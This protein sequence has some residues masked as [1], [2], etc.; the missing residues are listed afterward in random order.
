MGAKPSPADS[1][2]P[3]FVDPSG[4]RWKV[5]LAILGL[6]GLL[7]ALGLYLLAH[8]LLETPV[9]SSPQGGARHLAVP[10]PALP[11]HLGTVPVFGDGILQE[12]VV[13]RHVG[14]K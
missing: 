12:I 11:K 3:V 8:S 13:I 5:I 1:D 4:R 9:H 2:R 7:V 14:G 6:A 10:L